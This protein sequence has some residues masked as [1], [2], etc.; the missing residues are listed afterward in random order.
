M[1]ASQIY[2]Q[3]FQATPRVQVRAPGRVNLIGEHI[4]YNGG[5][6]L[7]FAIARGIE[8]AATP[9]SDGKFRLHAAQF[10]E[11]YEG[12]LPAAKT[13][14][15]FWSNYVF[16]VIH[17]FLKLGYE[18]PGFDAVID[19]DI[20]LSSG[21]S[22]SAALEVGTAWMLQNLLGS[23]LTRM[24]IAQLGQRAENKYVGVNC[25]I[26]D[27]AASAL[28]EKGRALLLDCNSLRFEH[29]ALELRGEAVLVV[30]HSGIRRGLSHSAYNERRGACDA[31]L[32]SIRIETGK[33]LPCLCA[34]TL[35]DL[36][37]SKPILDEERY[38]RARHAITE[39]IRVREMIE[40]LSAA[41]FVRAGE[42]LNA[43]HGSLR[44]DY[45]VSCEELDALTDMIRKHPGSF[46]SRLTGA[47]F[48]GCT[49][50]L[51]RAAEA[52]NLM[53]KVKKDYYGARGME[54]LIFATAAENGVCT[55]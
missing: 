11:T 17:E 36:E 29:P 9:R 3:H 8:I 51:V 2:Q 48:G 54:A 44:D 46:G 24:E 35:E 1:N 41:D 23:Q 47:G 26:M 40:A 34:A 42:I 32:D 22:S 10:G 4:D 52:E 13:A 33:N 49:V 16:G 31:A 53:E 37:I 39:E 38:R 18:V 27:Q 12:A 25:G 30:A 45:D 14:D 21:L 50:S 19:G 7:P 5:H 15:K 43:S 20:P 6:V 55:L 28:G